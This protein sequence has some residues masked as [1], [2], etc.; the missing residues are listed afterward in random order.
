MSFFSRKKKKKKDEEISASTTKTKKL[1]VAER[2]AKRKTKKKS[3]YRIEEQTTTVDESNDGDDEVLDLSM[4]E[5]MNEDPFQSPT[6]LNSSSKLMI[7][8][9]KSRDDNIEIENSSD[10]LELSMDDNTL[11]PDKAKDFFLV[12]NTSYQSH[13]DKSGKHSYNKILKDTRMTRDPTF[14]ESRLNALE[15]AIASGRISMKTL[16][17]TD[18]RALQLKKD[19]LKKN[20]SVTMKRSDQVKASIDNISSFSS[21]SSKEY[22]LMSEIKTKNKMIDRL[23]QEVDK[24]SH[25]LKNCG[26]E[27]VRLRQGKNSLRLDVQEL[28]KTL[29]ESKQVSV[30]INGPITEDTLRQIPQSERGRV[31][32]LLGEKLKR[33]RETN[34]HYTEKIKG[35]RYILERMVKRDQH[36]SSLKDAHMS[37][38]VY[39]QQL[40]EQVQD[41]PKIKT[42]VQIQEKTIKRLENMLEMQ[43]STSQSL[44]K[45]LNKMHQEEDSNENIAIT[46]NRQHSMMMNSSQ[47]STIN[48]SSNNNN[49]NNNTSKLMMRGSNDL[50]KMFEKKVKEL[51]AMVRSKD[52][53]IQSLEDQLVKNAR[54]FAK[55]ATDLKLKIQEYQMSNELMEEAF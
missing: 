13:L 48:S 4:D 51:Q 21:S 26:R 17:A 7:T 24:L 29:E 39:I 2:R 5:V 54:L 38:A 1:S 47:S 22:N 50:S 14:E 12:Q 30:S 20:P 36:H 6:K 53:R 35:L 8:H 55:E 28:N 31:I 19:L 34:L 44:R 11:S 45:T 37:Q 33:E 41:M 42:A 16:S 52:S 15:A 46:T 23:S 43:V 32:L 25:S 40:Q 3:L 9:D 18:Q 10:V 49:H 27:I